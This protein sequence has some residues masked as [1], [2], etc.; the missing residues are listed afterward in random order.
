MQYI[1]IQNLYV[2]PFAYY[3]PNP[4]FIFSNSSSDK[5]IYFSLFPYRISHQ[6]AFING[7]VSIFLLRKTIDIT[8]FSKTFRDTAVANK[9]YFEHKDLVINKDLNKV[10]HAAALVSTK[11]S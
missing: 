10:Y 3:A 4:I 7:V 9:K 2:N 6:G 1:L 11:Y 5:N 8:G